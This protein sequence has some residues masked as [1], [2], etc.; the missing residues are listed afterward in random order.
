MK[1]AARARNAALALA[2][3]DIGELPAVDNPDRKDRASSDFRY[4]CESYF[5][6]TFHLD[7]SEDHLK[8]IDKIER[9]V[10]EGGLFALAMAR[11]SG[12]SSI[13]EVACIWAVLYGHR[14]FV[15]LSR[16]SNPQDRVR[17]Q[18]TSVTCQV[19]SEE[20]GNVFFIF[21]ATD[22]P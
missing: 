21:F 8:V 15:C 11:G 12:K 3:R 16:H 10:V 1:E 17:G 7:W 20:F 22:R 9:A 4:F 18:E 6:L 13:A 14:E 19:I 2:G 5:P